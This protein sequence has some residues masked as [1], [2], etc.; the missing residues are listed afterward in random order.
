MWTIVIMLHAVSPNLPQSK[1]SIVFPTTGYEE[2]LK[3]RD[4]VIR[5]WASDRYRV[6]ANC[7]LMKQ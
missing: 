6:S 3:T 2:C 7:I 5:G 4:A 1:G